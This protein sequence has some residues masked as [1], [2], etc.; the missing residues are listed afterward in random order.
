MERMDEEKTPEASVTDAVLIV[1]TI[2]MCAGAT[3]TAVLFAV[4]VHAIPAAAFKGIVF[5]ALML[6]AATFINS[7]LRG[8]LA[9]EGREESGWFTAFVFLSQFFLA[10]AWAAMIVAGVIMLRT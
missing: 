2:L 4:L 9:E 1:G 6:I 8:R 10:L 7:R 5:V 3:A